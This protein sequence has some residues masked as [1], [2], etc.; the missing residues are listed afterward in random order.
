MN[1]GKIKA[2][3]ILKTSG[4]YWR[5][6]ATKEMLTRIYAIS[7]PNKEELDHYLYLLEEAKK[8]D[9]RMLGLKLDLFSFKEEGVGMPF[10]HPSGMI[11]WNKLLSFWRE[12]HQKENYLEIKTPIML[13]QELW[14]TSGH[15]SYYRSNMYTSIID[16][17]EVAIKPMNCP[18]GMLYYKST[19]HSYREFPLRVGEIGHV[20][21]HEM[22]GS[23][24]GLLRVRSFHQDDA[25]IFMAPHQI[26]DEIVNVLR[27]ADTIYK[28]FGLSY[29]FELST[30]PE[31]SKTIGSD[32][33]W[34]MAT[35]GLKSALDEWGAPY[36]VNEGDGAFY[37]PKI[38][39]HVKDAL[40]RSWQCGTIQLDMALPE[41][42]KLEYTDSDGKSKKP[43]MIHR[44][45]FGSIER[46]FAILIEHFTGRFPLWISPKQICI[47]PVADRHIDFSL[48]LAET[49]RN[50]NL[51]C[52]VD[53]S[54]ESVSKKIRDA[55]ILQ[56][57][58]MLTIGDREFENKKISIR[59]RDNYQV[60]QITLDT[61]LKELTKEV[62]TKSL[63]P[64][65]S[66]QPIK[67][68]TV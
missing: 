39:L 33:E 11:I 25:H 14:E 1:I 2:F 40:G 21:R 3:K 6:D 24:N 16:E 36:R 59:T 50:H 66:N 49:I 56:Y 17:K 9:H 61:F 60:D 19:R 15:W 34:E 22:S 52:D 41:R 5:G 62:E 32:E 23:I 29:N 35:E 27:L 48:Q 37:G 30:R 53:T 13:S 38:D 63:D 12:L 67:C 28:T 68:K 42:F 10:I 31:K 45:L 26:K 51:L 55:Q 65:F 54:N 57:N 47:I 64:V 44:A 18:G 8:R 7:F 46:F 58:Y 20:H 43:V 4:A